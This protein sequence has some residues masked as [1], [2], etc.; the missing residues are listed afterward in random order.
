MVRK[1]GRKITWVM[2]M[3]VFVCLVF[4]LSL[5]SVDA[6]EVKGMAYNANAS[7]ADNLKTMVGKP[8]NI[9][10]QS[11]ATFSGILKTVGTH[12]VHLEKLSGKEYYDALIRLEDISAIDARFR[13]P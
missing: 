10:L 3:M 13:E 1:R 6:K 4:M 9:T 11:G 8:V 12:L 7:M 2:G 5:S